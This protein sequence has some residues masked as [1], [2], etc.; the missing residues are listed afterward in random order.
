M[1]F[2]KIIYYLIKV[3]NNKLHSGLVLILANPCL[4]SVMIHQWQFLRFLSKLVLIF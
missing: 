4:I 2:M 3:E 1:Y